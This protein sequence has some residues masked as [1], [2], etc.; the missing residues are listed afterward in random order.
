MTVRPDRR[1]RN[2]DRAALRVKVNG[3]YGARWL[4]ESSWLR[5]ATRSLLMAEPEMACSSPA[6]TLHGICYVCFFVVSFIYVNSVAPADIRA[7]AQAF[8]TFVTLGAGMYVGSI[9]AGWIQDFYTV[10]AGPAAL[11]SITKAFSLCHAC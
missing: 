2:D 5:F 6:L 3:V 7:S 8:I 4:L 10:G 1:D 9:F 11:L